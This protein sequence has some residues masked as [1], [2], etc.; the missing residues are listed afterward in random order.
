MKGILPVLLLTMTASAGRSQAP[1]LF[2]SFRGG[3]DGLHL[4]YSEDGREWVDLNRLFLSPTVGSKLMRDPHILRG[5]DGLY[6]MVWTSG[7]H[8]AGIGYASSRNLT[9]WTKQKYLPLMEKVAGTKTCWAPELYLDD[10]TGK[11]IIL[12]SSNVNDRARAYYTLTRDF[13]TFS[14]PRILFDP[15]FNNIDTTMVRWRDKFVIFFKEFDDQQNRKWGSILSAIADMPL[16]PY[17]LLPDP[18][19]ARER[20]EGPA[21]VVIDDKVLL[22]V[23]YYADH[24]YGVLESTDL[25]KWTDVTMS[26]AVVPGQRHGSIFAVPAEVLTEL[27]AN[28]RKALAGVPPPILDGFNA[29]PSIRVFGDTYYIYP[30]SDKPHWMTTDFSVWSSKNL[31]QWKRQGMILDVTKDLAWA[32]IRAWAPDCV[33]RDG[34]SS[35]SAP[36]ARSAS[37]PPTNLRVR[38]RTHWAGR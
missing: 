38:S 22:Y 7:W 15:G 10:K 27:R 30:T 34:R 20:A 14:E 11:Y 23:D 21:A 36:T 28:E 13:E 8:D 18:A 29:D 12:W 3:G 9:E 26:T 31:V 16:G 2:T 19:L 6:H 17:A 37:R 25:K 4:A 32:K 35:T 24:R 33:E 5:P 1:R